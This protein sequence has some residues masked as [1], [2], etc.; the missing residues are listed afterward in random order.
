MSQELEQAKEIGLEGFEN[1]VKQI[2][3]KVAIPAVDAAI[4]KSANKIDDVA[5]AAL[6]PTV[7]EEAHKLIDKIYIKK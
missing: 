4:A 5:W 3:D 7:I 2:C 1:I 6:K